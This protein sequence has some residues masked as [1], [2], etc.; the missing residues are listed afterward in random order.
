MKFVAVGIVALAMTVGMGQPASAKCNDDAAV[1]A[2]R[3]QV[4]AS[5]PCNGFANH[6]QFVKCSRDVANML[7]DN[8][9]LPNNCK[10]NV[11]QCAARSSC[12]RNNGNAVACCVTGQ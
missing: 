5:C 11:T 8:N 4:A 10:A 3:A 1:A 2:A 9:Q 6:G 12:G 7:A